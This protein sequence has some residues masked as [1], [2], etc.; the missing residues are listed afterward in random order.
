MR[1]SRVTRRHR[2]RRPSSQSGRKTGRAPRCRPCRR[3]SSRRDRCRW[4]RRGSRVA[5]WPTKPVA[6]ACAKNVPTPTSTMPARTCGKMRGQHQRQADGGDRERAP[7]RRPRSEARHRLAGEQRRDDGGQEDKIDKTEHPFVRAKAAARTSTKFTKVNVPIKANRMQKPMPK[8]ARSDG[9]RQC[10]II[11]ANGDCAVGIACIGSHATD[12][13]IHQHR[14]G[15][16]EQREEIEIRCQPEACRR[17][18]PKP[19][20][21]SGCWRRCR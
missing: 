21:R 19:A 17:P 18:L 14:A 13:E 4:R 1:Q 7:D 3:R 5:A 6:E 10:A 9:L 16:I 2:R 20:G 11:A 8:A 15:E 12:G